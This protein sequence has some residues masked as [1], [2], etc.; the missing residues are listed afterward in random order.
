MKSNKDHLQYQPRT[1]DDWKLI[2]SITTN[3]DIHDFE[4][5]KKEYLPALSNFKIGGGSYIRKREVGTT[6]NVSDFF[7]GDLPLLV[8]YHNYYLS[9][10][11]HML[12]LLK[13]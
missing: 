8:E 10:V 5:L 13:E 12:G 1:S 7:K 4:L 11:E 3:Y 2:D 6:E 9:K